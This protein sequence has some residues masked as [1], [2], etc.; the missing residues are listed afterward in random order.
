M[1][2]LLYGVAYYR[3]YL[4]EERLDEDIRLMKAAGINVVRIA[5]STWSS[6]EP[7]D[8]E[9]DFS[10]VLTVLD[11]MHQHQISV[12]IGTPTYALPGWLAK[13]H[14]SVMAETPQGVNKY[15]HRQKMDITSPV[16]LFYAERIIRR[17]LAAT[18]RHPAVIGFQ[19][20]NE[21]KYYDTCGSHVQRDFV[22]HLKQQFA[23]DTDKL[24]A[25]F[26]LDYWSNRIDDWEDFPPLESTINASLGAA[27]Q[28]Y[29]RELVSQFLCW[30]VRLVHEYRL[31]QQFV[32]HNFDFE[33]RTWSFGVRGEV[34]HFVASRPL[35]ITGVD[36]YH[37]GQHALTGAEIAFCGDIARTT[38]DNNYL[39]LETQAQ[40]FKNWT[41]YPGQLRLQAFSH[42]ASGA[43][44]VGYWHWHSLHNSYE[45]YWKGLLSHDL[46]PNPVYHEAQQIGQQFACLSPTLA[47]LKKCNHV[48]LLVSN[49]SL[50]A[51][52]WHPYQGHQF[53]RHK[54][55]Q[56]NDQ[57]R[58][59]YDALYRLNIEVDVLCVDDP[60]VN[61]YQLLIAPLLYA[62]SDQSLQRLNQFVEQGGHV[63]YSFKSGFA[64][65]HLKVRHQRQ[66]AVI[67]E[68]IGASYQLFVEPHEVTLQSDVLQLD[69]EDAVVTDWMELLETDGADTEIWARYQHPYWDQ[70]AA[71]VHHQYGAGT[72]TYIGCPLTAGV[73]SGVITHLTRRIELTIDNGGLRFPL[74]VKRAISRTGSALLF[75]FNYS[76][77]SQEVT[78]PFAGGHELLTGSRFAQGSV[79]TLPDWGVAIFESETA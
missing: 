65:Q 36:I 32:T 38:K 50:T 19:V 46:Q 29:Q 15:G 43:A 53:G 73:L 76:A 54:Q 12:I 23:G 52:D 22:Q 48:A 33:W 6:Y 7:R 74:V 58:S 42:I 30:Q 64:N 8:G 35:D 75:L 18:A 10:Q 61:R 26:G 70:Y 67:R 27:F 28:R 59:Y 68:T 24:N 25:E 14:P 60:R 41:P 57:V 2:K 11:R 40:A 77:Q 31:P 78:L 4:P 20:D 45:T 49:D 71:V 56:Y 55:H 3:E 17:L 72:A 5:E 51:I 66:P 21:T 37:P 47:G 34:D 44:M 1:E 63:L 13:K 69:G 9:F 79:L 16:Y 62:V 39:V